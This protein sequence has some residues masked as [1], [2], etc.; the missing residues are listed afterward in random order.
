MILVVI[1][2][3]E[4]SVFATQ[5]LPIDKLVS[6]PFQ[7]RVNKADPDF[8]DLVASIQ[9]HGMI[10]PVVVR[11]LHD[12]ESRYE[13]LAGER[14]LKAAK[15]LKWSVVPCHIRE[16][17]EDVAIVLQAEENLH[18]KDYDDED[19]VHL[20]SEL[21]RLKKW[22]ATEI[23][24][25][26]HRSYSWV[27]KYLPEQYKDKAKMESGQVG[28]IESGASRRE[29]KLEQAVKTQETPQAIRTMPTEDL[30]DCQNCRMGFHI[31]KL[32]NLNG[33]DLCPQC[34]DRLVKLPKVQEKTVEKSRSLEKWE[35][36]VASMKVQHSKMEIDLR[37]KLSEAGFGVEM[38]HDFCLQHTIPDFYF[39]KEKVA[40]YVDGEVH[41]G[42][43]EHDD[44][45]RGQLANRYGLKVVPL[46]YKGNSQT[47]LEDLFKRI[48]GELSFQEGNK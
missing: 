11:P 42:K 32:K 27:V 15:E 46:R 36:R 44:W 5:L 39:P 28:G 41:E 24:K 8:A 43:E 3:S 16:V 45:I 12:S 2:L 23:A 13:V 19:K 38:D 20:V 47:V 4:H 9:E 35:N 30:M 17:S 18:R 7:S 37:V 21:A 33:Q 48:V 14:R 31:S 6:M 22:D 25:R 34:Y 1:Q 26:L 29:A 10:E 40:V